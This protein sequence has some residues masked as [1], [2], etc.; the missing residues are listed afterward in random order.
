LMAPVNPSD[1]NMIEGTYPTLPA[2]P[3]VAGSEGV[4]KIAAIGDG[5]KGLHVDDYVI[6][7]KAGFGTWRTHAV[8]G[9]TDLI[10]LPEGPDAGGKLKLEYLATMS[11]NPA[12]ALRLVEDSKLSKGDVIIQN[13]ANSMVGLSVMQI[14]AQRGIKT[15]NLIR[16]R[17]NQ[18]EIVEKMKAYGGF[19]V[20]TDNYMQTPEFR[21]LI[22]DLPKP[23]LALNGL[24][25][26]TVTE[27]SRLLDDNGTLVTYGAMSRKPITVPSS[28]FLFKNI[29][30]K[31]FWLQKWIDTH[32]PQ[33]REK[34]YAQLIDMFKS[35]QLRLWIER[36][37]FDD[38]KEA[39]TRS[40][41]AYRDR[42]VVLSME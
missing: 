33:E 34:M 10:K 35:N 17:P 5:V 30:L 25:G 8:C 31:G 2:L 19:I 38:W 7:S 11:I 9:E 6:P 14:A 22:S 12:T 24:G 1:I 13:A 18:A 21:R 26:P 40:Q 20:C 36:H 42:K 29:T 41:T 39:L 16:D 27:M 3:A 4:G 37:K 23:K 32:T 28:P 15:I